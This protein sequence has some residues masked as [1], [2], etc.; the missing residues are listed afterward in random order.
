MSEPLPSDDPAAD[1]ADDPDDLRPGFLDRALARLATL[2]FVLLFL[3]PCVL[4]APLLIPW[5]LWGIL[6][7]RRPAARRSAWLM[8]VF[9][10]AWTI[11]FVVAFVR[12]Y[13][14]GR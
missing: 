6:A 3:T 2:H 11:W 9:S 8:L 13:R 10:T 7:C 12:G 4:F 5:A 1:Y 14:S